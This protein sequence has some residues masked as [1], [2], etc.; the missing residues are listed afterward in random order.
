MYYSVV[1]Q[2]KKTKRRQKN[3][4]KTGKKLILINHNQL[5][6]PNDKTVAHEKYGSKGNSLN[7]LKT[8]S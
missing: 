8:G 1:N 2:R 3:K 5:K 6:F 4:R 7:T